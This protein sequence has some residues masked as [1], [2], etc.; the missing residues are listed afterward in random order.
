MGMKRSSGDNVDVELCKAKATYKRAKKA[1]KQDK[2]NNSLKI[3]KKIAKKA[4]IE[5]ESILP[6]AATADVTDTNSNHHLLQIRMI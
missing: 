3:A 5:A 6:T 4:L 1:Y 2:S